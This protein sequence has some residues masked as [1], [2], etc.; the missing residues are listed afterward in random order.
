MNTPAKLAP[1]TP[2]LGS[3]AKSVIWTDPSIARLVWLTLLVEADAD[4]IVSH[5][6]AELAALVTEKGRPMVQPSEVADA[7]GALGSRV[8]PLPDGRFRLPNHRRY[9]DIHPRP[10]AADNEDRPNGST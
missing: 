4:G 1:F 9:Q 8:E 7:L 10:Q 6:I 2:I 5:D 3:I